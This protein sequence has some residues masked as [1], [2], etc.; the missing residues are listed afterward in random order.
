MQAKDDDEI[1]VHLGEHAELLVE[2]DVIDLI[3]Q[4]P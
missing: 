1:M 2:K 3:R 4:K